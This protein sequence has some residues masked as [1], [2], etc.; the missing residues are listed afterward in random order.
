VIELLIV[1]FAFSILQL[2]L[3]VEEEMHCMGVM[4]VSTMPRPGDTASAWTGRSRT[5]DGR[6]P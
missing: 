3:T 4:S 5:A 2:N 1:V 6:I